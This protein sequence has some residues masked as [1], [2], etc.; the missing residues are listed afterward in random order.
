[1]NST[2][3]MSLEEA[4]ADLGLPVDELLRLKKELA[5]HIPLKDG[6]LVWTEGARLRVRGELEAV[7]LRAE[8]T[9]R[10]KARHQAKLEAH[11]SY[12]FLYSNENIH[13][14]QQKPTIVI[15]GKF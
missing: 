4:A 13:T 10:D 6:K 12:E 3:D 8:I 14:R 9:A 2:R 11:E 5:L 7:R 1:M 15:G